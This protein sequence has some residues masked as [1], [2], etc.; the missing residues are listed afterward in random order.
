MHSQIHQKFKEVLSCVFL[1]G[2]CFFVVVVVVVDCCCCA[3]MTLAACAGAGATRDALLG[4]RDF[5]DFSAT[6]GVGLVIGAAGATDVCSFTVG[7]PF[8]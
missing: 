5:S 6:A 7:C 1:G 2:C 3:S 4:V 8:D